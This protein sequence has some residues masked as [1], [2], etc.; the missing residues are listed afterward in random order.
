MDWY[1]LLCEGSCDCLDNFP[2]VVAL[3]F[4]TLRKHKLADDKFDLLHSSGTLGQ[5]SAI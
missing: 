1:T 4:V 3:D 2:S 5:V